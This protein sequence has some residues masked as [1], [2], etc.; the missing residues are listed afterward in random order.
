VRV[1]ARV[2]RPS[3]ILPMR[4]DVMKPGDRCT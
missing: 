2:Y 4:L 1:R 3:A